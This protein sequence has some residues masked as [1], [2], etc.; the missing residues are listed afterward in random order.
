MIENKTNI[1][2]LCQIIFISE[3]MIQ[4][5]WWFL[6]QNQQKCEILFMLYLLFVYRVFNLNV[7]D[8]NAGDKIRNADCTVNGGLMG[9]KHTLLPKS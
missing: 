5:F 3:N 9:P 7:V 4:Q 8:T 2:S 6:Q 1:L